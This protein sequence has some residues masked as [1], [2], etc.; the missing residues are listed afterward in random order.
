LIQLRRNLYLDSLVVVTCSTT[1]LI[2]PKT[3]VRFE[4]THR[5]PKA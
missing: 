3:D 1:E 2:H 4:L 5:A